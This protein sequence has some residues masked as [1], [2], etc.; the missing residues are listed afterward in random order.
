[1]LSEW[2]EGERERGGE[3]VEGEEGRG[4]GGRSVDVLLCLELSPTFKIV[5]QVKLIQGQKHVQSQ[6]Q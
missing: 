5:R 2:R 6:V 4:E 3:G 1:M